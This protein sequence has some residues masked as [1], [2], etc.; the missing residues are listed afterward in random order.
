MNGKRRPSAALDNNPFLEYK[1]YNSHSVPLDV[2]VGISRLE[3]PLDMKVTDTDLVPENIMCKAV[4]YSNHQSMTG[5]IELGT[6]YA[7]LDEF[8]NALIWDYAMTFPL[9][10]SNLSS[11]S[12]ITIT[13]YT[14]SGEPYGGTSIKLFDS[15]GMLKQ[16]KQKLIFFFNTVGDSKMDAL[17]STPG[18]TLYDT[19]Y[20][21]Q[22]F[23]F[24]MEKKLESYKVMMMRSQSTLL[25]TSNN[26]S[27]GK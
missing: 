21:K 26:T 19:M 23:Q 13:A 7:T 27:I 3:L 22:D 9:K 11:N 16:G 20:S 8:R 5:N 1:W 17:N 12:I 4:L 18:D 6:F 14:P 2:Q 15:N 24:I 25:Y 10:V